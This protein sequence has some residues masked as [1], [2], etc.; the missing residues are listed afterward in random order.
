M[1]IFY[2]TG[3]WGYGNKGDNAIFEGMQLSFKAK[4]P[5]AKLVITSYSQEEMKSQHDVISIP[6]VHR[7]LTNRSPLALVRWLSVGLWRLSGQPVWLAPSLRRHLQRMQEASVV[8]LG[9]GGYF[10]DAWPDMLRCR[11]VE[12]DL[13]HAAGTPVMLYG[14]TIGPFKQTTIVKSL[15]RQLRRVAMIAYRDQQ[16][17]PVLQACGVPKEKIVYTADEANLLRPIIARSERGKSP[18]TLKIGVMVQNFRPHLSQTGPSPAGSIKDESAYRIAL[19]EALSALAGQQPLAAFTFIPSTRWDESFCKQIFEQMNQAMPGRAK[20][21]ANPS[22]R[23]FIDACQAVDL[24]ISTNMHPVILAATAGAPSV[25]ISYHYKLDDYMCSIGLSDFSLKI[26]DFSA[27]SL[28]EK[29]IDA[30]ARLEDLSQRVRMAHE[31]VCSAASRNMQG[32]ET[33]VT[34]LNR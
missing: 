19:R 30:L 17:L 15:A 12:F 25:A 1:T 18:P 3:G 20:M 11:Y 33:I 28:L 10:N 2:I 6:S 24:M 23:Q 32:L 8:V 4:Y 9:G 14:Q 31:A 27:D 7:L 34:S 5:D 22:A 16:S 13:A 29:C 26:D 21:L